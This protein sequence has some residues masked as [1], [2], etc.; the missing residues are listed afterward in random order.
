MEI[1]FEQ[2]RN[3]LEILKGSFLH[4][5]D[6]FIRG[7]FDYGSELPKSDDPIFPILKFP[8]YSFLRTKYLN[9]I[10][11]MN[12]INNLINPILEYLFKSYGYDVY[13]IP[14]KYI[15][16]Y[17]SVSQLES[18]YPVELV[19]KKEDVYI[20]LRYTPF[21]IEL[22]KI[23][24]VDEK[25]N[26]FGLQINSVTELYYVCWGEKVGVYDKYND[27]KNRRFS[28]SIADFFEKYFSSEEYDLVLNF[29]KEM[30]NEVSKVIGFQ[31]YQRLI[32]NNVMSFKECVLTE[33]YKYDFEKCKY[34][35]LNEVNKNRDYCLK[36]ILDNTTL[37]KINES[38]FKERRYLV[39]FGNLNFAKSLITSEYLFKIFENGLTLDYT[40]IVSGYIKCVEQLSDYIINKV[41]KPANNSKYV[42]LA[43]KLSKEDK[44]LLGNDCIKLNN[45]N[46]VYMSKRNELYYKNKLNMGELFYFFYFNK[47]ELFGKIIDEGIFEKIFVVMENY[48]ELRNCYL[49]KENIDDF[50]IVKT[51]RNNTYFLIC[52]ILGAT[53]LADFVNQ[54]SISFDLYDFS[55]ERLYRKII[56]NIN[57]KYIIKFE[58]GVEHKVIKEE[59]KNGIKYKNDGSIVDAEL[60]FIE[61]DKFP[62]D[63]P[64]YIKMLNNKC[65]QVKKYN[66]NKNNMISEICVVDESGKIQKV[67]FKI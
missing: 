27:N 31:S 26:Y 43:K 42:Y 14:K 36:G 6:V 48:V 53:N 10:L 54:E 45:K 46:Y 60:I 7:D 19:V 17:D 30:V 21:E 38:F 58:D 22:G 37:S 28:I 4:A 44:L 61:V 18:K 11:E 55:F 29:I 47:I 34:I 15:S 67:D 64:E 2:L 57:Y 16:S 35:Y 50:E 56:F 3:E 41:I 52:L 20:G 40:A 25:M 13:R 59:N 65:F 23:K 1:I 32:P 63:Y 51:V 24:R 9:G 5:F 62:E 49:H 33:F 8:D 12:I 66:V 39:L